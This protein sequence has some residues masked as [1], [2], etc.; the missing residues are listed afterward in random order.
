MVAVNFKQDDM[1]EVLEIALEHAIFKIV[2][3][4]FIL[5]SF[6]NLFQLP[7]Q[8]LYNLTD[9]LQLLGLFT[10]TEL[11]YTPFHRA[12]KAHKE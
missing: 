8:L 4:T 12:K 3:I 10:K 7:F 6:S 5:Y 11:M 2:L 9:T 1:C